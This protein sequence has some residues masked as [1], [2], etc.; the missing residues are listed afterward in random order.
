L[1][2]RAKGFVIA[3]ESKKHRHCE[4]ERS[5]LGF[6]VIKKECNDSIAEAHAGIKTWIASLSLAMTVL[7]L[8]L[9]MT[10]LSLSLAM[11][12]KNQKEFLL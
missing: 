5:N 2:A 1:R 8:V 7:S 9:A 10:V 11:T 12:S 6:N 3:S 4:R